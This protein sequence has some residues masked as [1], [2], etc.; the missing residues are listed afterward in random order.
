MLS[1][2]QNQVY[3]SN[4]LAIIEGESD[5]ENVFGVADKVASSDTGGEVQETELGVPAAGESELAVGREDDVFDEPGMHQGSLLL[6]CCWQI[7]KNQWAVSLGRSA[8]Q[9]GKLAASSGCNLLVCWWSAGGSVGLMVVSC[10]SSSEL[11]RSHVCSAGQVKVV[12]WLRGTKERNVLWT[13]PVQQCEVYA[14]CGAFGTCNENTLPFCNCPNGFNP[15]SSNDWNSMSYSGG[16]MRRIELVCGNNEKKDTFLEYPNMRLPKHPRSV[17]VGSAEEC[18]SNCLSN[19][20]CTAYAYDSDGCSIWIGDLFN[21]Q[22]LLENDDRG[23]TLYLRVT[24]SKYSSGKN[25][26]GIIGVVLGSVSVVLLETNVSPPEVTELTG[27]DVMEEKCGFAAICFVAFLPD[28]LDSK[29]KG[30]NKYLEM[31]LSIA[32]KFKRS[33][34]NYVWAAAGKQPD[35]ENHLG[36]DGYGFVEFNSH[37]AAERVLQTYNRTHMF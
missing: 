9:V 10:H 21:M 5:K 26:K 34:Y 1:N 17:A 27:P 16:C 22:E 32:E 20:S 31:L 13:L 33:L 6:V 19:C 29:D 18:E 11:A 8:L 2:A 14:F 25:K 7:C 15:T 37:A 12:T 24:V 23:R 35:L 36:V 4:M 3:H 28:I 30:R